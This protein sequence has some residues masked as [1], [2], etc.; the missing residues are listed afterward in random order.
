MNASFL[1]SVNA[2][3]RSILEP[4]APTSTPSLKL[5]ILSTSTVIG[6][7]NL[8]SNSLFATAFNDL[9]HSFT[10][11]TES[12]AVRLSANA[13]RPATFNKSLAISL[14]ANAIR[15]SPLLSTAS[16]IVAMTV[17]AIVGVLANN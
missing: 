4:S 3:L 10:V 6:R 13:S 11:S 9:P 16:V 5:S 1:Q 7:K 2:N 12:L 15:S 17:F 14:L 8:T